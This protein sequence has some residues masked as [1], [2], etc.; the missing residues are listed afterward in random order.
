MPKP[1]RL[2]PLFLIC[3]IT[4]QGVFCVFVSQSIMITLQTIYGLQSEYITEYCYNF[5]EGLKMFI[6]N[7]PKATL[8]G[9]TGGQ[10]NFVPP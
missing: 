5:S 3:R 8:N 1:Y 2:S 6:Y 10:F 7:T 4:R 9:W